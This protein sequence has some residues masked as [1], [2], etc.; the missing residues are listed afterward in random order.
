[1]MEKALE[2]IN[3]Y[4]RAG[5]TSTGIKFTVWEGGESLVW[6]RVKELKII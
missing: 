4:L 6:C 3:K 5:V 1:M 2:K